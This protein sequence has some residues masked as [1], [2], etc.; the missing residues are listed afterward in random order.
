ME[1]TVFDPEKVNTISIYGFGRICLSRNNSRAAHCTQ[2]DSAIEA[3]AGF[4][5]RSVRMGRIRSGYFC[6]TCVGISLQRIHSWFFNKHFEILQPVIF[7]APRAIDGED[8]ASAW[9]KGGI[10]SLFERVNTKKA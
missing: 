2:C 9:V 10:Q 4:Q 3:G 7:D 5:F 6:K 8:L 1:N